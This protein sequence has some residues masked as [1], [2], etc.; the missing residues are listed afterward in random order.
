MQKP[1]KKKIIII[2]CLVVIFSIIS[3][4]IYEESSMDTYDQSNAPKQQTSVKTE[5]EIRHEYY[6]TILHLNWNI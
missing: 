5:E 4:D 3:I 1:S 2:T 6:K